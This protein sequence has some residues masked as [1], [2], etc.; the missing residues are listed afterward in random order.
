ML[1]G[2]LDFRGVCFHEKEDDFLVYRCALSFIEV[3]YIL[4]EAFDESSIDYASFLSEFSDNCVSFALAGLNVAF[5][6]VPVTSFVVHEEIVDLGVFQEH[7]SATRFFVI[8]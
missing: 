1:I 3:V 5:D 7:H 8:H 4:S 2:Q 6:E